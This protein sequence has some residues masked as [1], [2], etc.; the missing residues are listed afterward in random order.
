M[1]KVG[2]AANTWNLA[3]CIVAASCP[4][5]A[6]RVP[7]EPH[8]TRGRFRAK[9]RWAGGLL[10]GVQRLLMRE[11]CWRAAAEDITDEAF[12]IISRR[13]C[14]LNNLLLHQH[15][16]ADRPR[17]HVRPRRPQGG[18]GG[19]P[20][21]NPLARPLLPQT[22]PSSPRVCRRRRSRGRHTPLLALDELE[23]SFL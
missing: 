4:I 7:L 16:Q 11:G 23:G 19:S 5:E 14:V 1:G 2:V 18:F 15:L 17:G 20:P 12:A 3:R 22:A 8:W 10:C 13:C 6:H 21:G 9:R